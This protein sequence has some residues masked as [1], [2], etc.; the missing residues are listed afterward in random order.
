MTFSFSL[1]FN[2]C[3]AASFT[4]SFLSHRLCLPLPSPL[5]YIIE[6]HT[7]SISDLFSACPGVDERAGRHEGS[8]HGG[9]HSLTHVGHQQLSQLRGRGG[10]VKWLKN[11]RKP[12]RILI[13]W[14]SA[15]AG[16]VTIIFPPPPPPPLLPISGL[17]PLQVAASRAAAVA[18]SICVPSWPKMAVM[19][20]FLLPSVILWKP[21]F[22]PF[23][24]K[25]SKSS[26]MM[27][28]FRE[29]EQEQESSF[30]TI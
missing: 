22:P 21:F 25:P 30:F 11:P 2:L 12:L 23:L 29:Q 6:Q 3:F 8:H 10:G 20:F 28:W 17:P 1:S 26:Y 9:V 16:H 19:N 15:D 24:P 27:W 5:F 13:S 14:S 18:E 4:I 7:E